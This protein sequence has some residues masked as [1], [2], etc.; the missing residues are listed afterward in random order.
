LGIVLKN[1]I[2]SQ[3]TLLFPWYPKLVVG[4]VPTPPF[5]AIAACQPASIFGQK[6]SSARNQMLFYVVIDSLK[7]WH[8]ALEV[9]VIDSL[10]FYV[11][12]D[13]LMWLLTH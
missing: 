1:L 3:K 11:V 4:L 13:S 7:C 10:L 9:V 8:F 12:I 5:I 2:P 6:F